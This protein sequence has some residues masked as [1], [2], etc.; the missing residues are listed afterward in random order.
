[1]Y[2]AHMQQHA[3]MQCERIVYAACVLQVMRKLRKWW[4]ARCDA[5]GFVGAAICFERLN[6]IMVLQY[7]GAVTGDV[8]SCDQE[9]NYPALVY[10][11]VRGWKREQF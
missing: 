11:G 8:D 9:G 10:H 7:C 2:I 6:G 3:R 5:E 1:M 4:C